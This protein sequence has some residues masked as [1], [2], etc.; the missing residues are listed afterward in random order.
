[1][2]TA[3]E[4]AYRHVQGTPRPVGDPESLEAAAAALRRAGQDEALE[5][6]Q[7][8]EAHE[9]VSASLR[10]CG[11][12]GTQVLEVEAW[13][14]GPIVEGVGVTGRADL[15]L[16]HDDGSLEVRDHKISRRPTS[17]ETL[18]SDRQLLLYAW[19]AE[20]R[21]PH[22][23]G[24]AVSHHYPPLRHTVRVP[25]DRHRMAQVVAELERVAATIGRDRR[26]SP[27]P[28]AHCRTCRW[29]VQCPAAPDADP[30]GGCR[31]R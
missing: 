1:V 25:V 9:M 14:R 28:G 4:I 6:A 24:L 20:Q 7:L 23:T 5:F 15:V 21:W 26:F 11:V 22:A 17:A 27:V 8:A 18:A 29:V 31:A 12:Q 13:L 10:A 30:M 2:H 19:M 16:A 3:L